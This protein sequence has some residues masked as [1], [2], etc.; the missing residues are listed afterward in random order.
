MVSAPLD[1]PILV[2]RQQIAQSADY[3]RA[4]AGELPRVAI[5]LGSGLGAFEREVAAA[6]TLPYADIPFFPVPRVEGHGGRLV[7]GDLAGQRVAVMV[8]RAHFYEGHSMHEI[9]LPLRVLRALGVQLLIVTNAAGGLNSQFRV[10]DLML[11]SDHIN[12]LGMTGQNPLHGPN[13]PELGPRFPDMTHAYD[14]ELRRI[15]WRVARERNLPAREGVYAMLSGPSFE[16]PAEIRFLRL[17]GGDSV[18][19]STAH[20]V[21]VARHA[22]MRVLGVSTISNVAAADPE[23]RPDLLGRAD[24]PPA[25]VTHE[26]VLQA[27]ALI[28]PRLS[29]LIRGVLSQLQLS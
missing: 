8:G 19:M 3:I 12:L 1:D 17:I 14:P 7:I 18:G 11:I 10:G 27:G 28:A 4:R 16:T 9:T 5:I 21:V 13:D 29:A 25:V 23:D 15:A 24:A 22:G 2:A 26:E 6:V 20:E